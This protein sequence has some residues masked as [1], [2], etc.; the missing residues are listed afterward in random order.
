MP[1]YKSI[2][3]DTKEDLEFARNQ[4]KNNE[5]DSNHNFFTKVILYDK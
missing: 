4:L 1:K 2:D 5:Q 3:I